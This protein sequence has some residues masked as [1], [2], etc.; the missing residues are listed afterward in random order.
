MAWRFQWGMSFLA[1]WAKLCTESFRQAGN[2]K[3]AMGRWWFLQWGVVPVPGT[4]CSQGSQPVWSLKAGILISG[5]SPWQ[6]P[7]EDVN[8]RKACSDTTPE[9]PETSST[10]DTISI[11]KVDFSFTTVCKTNCV[12]K[13]TLLFY[14]LFWYFNLIVPHIMTAP[15]SP[16]LCHPRC[17]RA[18]RP[19]PAVWSLS[20]WCFV[21]KLLWFFVLL[22]LK[23]AALWKRPPKEVKG[24][25]WL[26]MSW[27]RSQS[28][29]GYGIDQCF[30]NLFLLWLCTVNSVLAPENVFLWWL[31]MRSLIV[32][33]MKVRL[34]KDLPIFYHYYW[35][36]DQVTNYLS[37][38]MKHPPQ[39]KSP[40]CCNHSTT[41]FRCR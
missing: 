21:Q 10:K 4:G 36:L 14:K 34:Q 41:W 35:K 16:L 19:I 32:T 20:T 29:R 1:T 26:I 13:H 9:I 18:W 23:S 28:R 8:D 15:S 30:S 27:T 12:K 24:G 2:C 37:E 3:W 38:M 25:P 17:H 11:F 33:I 39:E 40:A 5:S 31:Q 7:R 6:M 22:C